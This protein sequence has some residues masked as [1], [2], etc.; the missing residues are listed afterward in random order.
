MSRRLL[1]SQ[2]FTLALC[3]SYAL[4]MAIA[5]PGFGS[6]ENAANIASA[7]LPLLV[8][9]AGQTLVLITGGIDLSVTS[10]IAV[11]SVAGAGLLTADQGPWTNYSGGIPAAIMVMLILGASLGLL[12]GLCVAILQM[13][14]FMVTLTS[15][16]F[17][18][19]LT[20]WLT[21]SKSIAGL[22]PG[23]L[24]LGQN[25]YVAAAIAGAVCLGTQFMLTRTLWGRRLRAVG[26]NAATARVSGVPVEGTIILAY[27]A[28]GLCAAVGAILIT[29]QLETG[30]PVQ[31]KENLLD[32][33]GATVIGGT[34]LFGGRGSIAW[35][36]SGVLLLALID[37]SLNLLNL[38]YFMI[39]IIKGGVI[40]LA[41]LVDVWRTRGAAA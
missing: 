30:S 16:M 31:W 21:H 33:I 13:P 23:F 29:A 8:V 7:L 39:M 4:G 24:I 32:V 9:A 22:P 1:Q 17:W 6:P 5:V 3:A 25:L 19:G 10:I 11:V 28:S 40:L 41:A 20:I 38:S 27:A 14:A 35:T 26:Y 36:F 12:N 37:N 18:S 34:S 15:M 2:F